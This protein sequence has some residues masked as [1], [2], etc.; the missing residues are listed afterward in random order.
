MVLSGWILPDLYEVKCSSCSTVNGHI[1]VVKRYLDNLKEVDL[2]TY[3]KIVMA[4][5]RE[6][7]SLP[8]LGLDD[9]AVVQLGWIKINNEPMKTIFYV[10][11]TELEFTVKRYLNLGYY[12]IILESYRK[13]FLV[14]IPS[15]KL[16]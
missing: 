3:E 5:Y 7:S 4:F 1:E 15:N 16:I 8:S 14:N 12:P 10:N 6:S 13:Q 11:N 9:F 2:K